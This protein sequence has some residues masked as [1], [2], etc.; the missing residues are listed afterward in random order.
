MDFER[1]VQNV[2]VSKIEMQS[3]RTILSWINETLWTHV[4]EMRELS[5]GAVYCQI[6]HSIWR[7]SINLSKVHFNT[8]DQWQ[9]VSNYKLLKKS[10]QKID[11]KKEIPERQLEQGRGHYD[12]ANWFYKLYHV[13][14]SNDPYDALA[15]RKG[16]II[17][18]RIFKWGAN[19]LDRSHTMLCKAPRNYLDEAYRTRSLI[20]VGTETVEPVKP[21]PITNVIQPTKEFRGRLKHYFDECRAIGMPESDSDEDQDE[22]KKQ[23]TDGDM[24]PHISSLMNKCDRIKQIALKESDDPVTAMLKINSIVFE[25]H[26]VPGNDEITKNWQKSKRLWSKHLNL[27]ERLWSRSIMFSN[28]KDKK[29]GE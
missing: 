10:F 5:T 9:Y 29:T 17:G 12:F 15:A 7:R 3:V 20:N 11:I 25:A 18:M 27:M 26:G 21:K 8:N 2:R 19:I 6:M 16:A 14:K 4:Y 22:S 24:P 23:K 1:E 28:Q 13:N